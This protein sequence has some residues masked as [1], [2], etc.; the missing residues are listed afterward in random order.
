VANAQESPLTTSVGTRIP[1]NST[2][3][4]NPMEGGFDTYVTAAIQKKKIPLRIVADRDKADFEIKGTVEKQ[5]AGWAKTIFISPLPAI[6]STM[7]IIDVRSGVVAY[8]ISS[9]K[10][11]AR[12][13]RKGSAEHLAKNLAQKMQN[14]G[15]MA[16]D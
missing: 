9:T 2:I 1:K 11:N 12:R 3:Y 6:D 14:D 16:K 7:Q 10:A 15:E 4:I 13:G 5:K 8:S